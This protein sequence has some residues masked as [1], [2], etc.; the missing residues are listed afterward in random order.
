LS[1]RWDIDNG[2]SL[3]LP[4]HLYWA[5]AKYEEFRE[6][7]INETI[8]PDKFEIL[9]EKAF[10]IKKWTNEELKELLKTLK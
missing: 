1:T 5:H 8:G 4:C 9:R 7:V 2:I 3:C 10:T 6:W